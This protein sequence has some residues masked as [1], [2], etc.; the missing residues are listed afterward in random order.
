MDPDADYNGTTINKIQHVDSSRMIDYIH[1]MYNKKE[2]LSKHDDSHDYS[3]LWRRNDFEKVITRIVDC[4][5]AIELGREMIFDSYLG[6]FFWT[7]RRCT[8]YGV[9]KGKGRTNSLETL[10]KSKM[11]NSA[12]MKLIFLVIASF[13]PE[14]RKG[15]ITLFVAFNKRFKDFEKL[16][17][18]PSI[19]SWSGSH[20]PVLKEEI[21]YFESLLLIFNKSDLLEHKQLIEKHISSLR[22]QM[23]WE[24]KR[25]F[26]DD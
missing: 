12:V 20:V 1:W 7:S 24:K 5:L 15:Y 9:D 21:D 10:Y 23:E 17:L 19:K 2:C 6:T 14:R 3:F 26:M 25:D 13:E 16:S 4:V 11:E 18:E 22:R 8:G